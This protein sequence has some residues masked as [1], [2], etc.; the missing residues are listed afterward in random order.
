MGTSVKESKPPITYIRVI[1]LIAAL[2]SFIS[3]VLVYAFFRNSDLLVYRITGRPIVL[4]RLYQTQ[5]NSGPLSDILVYNVPDG[6]WLLSGILFIRT[7]WPDKGAEGKIYILIFCFLAVLFEVLQL[8]N[9]MPGTFDV[10]D[11]MAMVLSAFVEGVIFTCFVQR[12]LS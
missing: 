3:G 7:L 1:L 4:N 12:R 6:L 9:F 8:F 10:L 5:G 11:L 2:A